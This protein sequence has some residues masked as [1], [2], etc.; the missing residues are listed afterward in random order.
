MTS[1]KLIY[2]R[3]TIVWEPIHQRK[4]KKKLHVN[5]IKEEKKKP[6]KKYAPHCIE[7]QQLCK[8]IIN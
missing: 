7:L 8:V 1:S 4:K 6:S 5:S 2:K 3:K